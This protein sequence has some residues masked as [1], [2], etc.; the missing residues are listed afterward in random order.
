MRVDREGWL[1]AEDGDPVVVRHPTVRTC[2][3]AVA[4]PLGIVWHWTGGC[5]GPGYA[6]RLALRTRTYRRGVDRAASWHVLVAKDGVI[7]QSAPFLVGT[8]HVRRPG[9][10]AGRHFENVN[11]ATVGCE[12]ENAGR[13]RKIGDR[14]CCWPYWS[15]PGAPRQ[16]RRPD[17]RCAVDA[18]RAMV[19]PGQGTFDAFPTEQEAAAARLLAALVA[20][21]GWTREVCV[22]GH[23]DFTTSKEDPGPLW[24]EAVLP[25]VLDVVFG[26]APAAVADVSAPARAQGG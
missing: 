5:G 14:F 6:E 8:W 4:Q 22:H 12:L 10:I 2:P 26:A 18:S 21:F 16:E 15:N 9:T 25:R 3:L 23:R 13:L 17:P 19:V 1:V 7:Y 20:R 11:R 24:A